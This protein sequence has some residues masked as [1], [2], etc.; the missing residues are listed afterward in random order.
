M[1]AYTVSNFVI[2]LK[3]ICVGSIKVVAEFILEE[4]SNGLLREQVYKLKGV[5]SR[6]R[7]GYYSPV[8]KGSAV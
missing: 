5:V 2:S 3:A 8:R 4:C 7:F 6:P 1:Y